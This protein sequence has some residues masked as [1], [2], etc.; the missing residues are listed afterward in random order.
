MESGNY[1]KVRAFFRGSLTKEIVKSSGKR[2]VKVKKPD[3]LGK[4]MWGLQYDGRAIEAKIVDLDWL[5]RFQSRQIDVRP[6][7]SL[8]VILYEEIS[9]GY[10]NEVVHRH[11]E[12]EKVDD[13]IRPPSQNK[14]AF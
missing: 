12:I 11:Y 10:D 7:D 5:A 14:I 8:R 6:G 2:V 13:V 1:A 9:Y 3:Y 4:S